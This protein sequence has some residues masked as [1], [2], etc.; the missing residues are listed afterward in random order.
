MYNHTHCPQCQ[1]RLLEYL[2][3]QGIALACPICRQVYRIAAYVAKSPT[4]SD[5]VRREAREIANLAWGIGLFALGG[6]L[7]AAIFGRSKRRR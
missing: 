5:K 4:F 6:V 1:V 7:L 2:I 3:E